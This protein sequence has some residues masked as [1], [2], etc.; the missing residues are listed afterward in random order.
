MLKLAREGTH[1]A[2]PHVGDICPC[3]RHPID[4]HPQVSLECP[5]EERWQVRG[6]EE[7]DT[8]HR[9]P[10]APHGTWPPQ[11]PGHGL[12]WGSRTWWGAGSGS[13]GHP[14][15]T[16]QMEQ[17]STPVSALSL[18][19]FPA[20][21]LAGTCHPLCGLGYGQWAPWVPGQVR[22]GHAPCLGQEV[23]G[24]EGEWVGALAP[25]WGRKEM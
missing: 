10:P 20:H 15:G 4:E 6:Q 2:G 19:P 14:G 1:M 3:T 11:Q 17:C 22:D 12:A 18:A 9:E 25:P 13:Q 8:Q 23:L 7:G 21:P 5:R 24:Q 16:R